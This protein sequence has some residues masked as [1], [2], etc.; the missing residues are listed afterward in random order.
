MLF[1]SK[2][3]KFEEKTNF[4]IYPLLRSYSVGRYFFH[5]VMMVLSE[6]KFYRSRHGLVSSVSAY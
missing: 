6:K 3:L 5:S 2:M 4:I 1:K